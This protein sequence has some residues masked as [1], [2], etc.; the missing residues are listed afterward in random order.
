MRTR[1]TRIGALAALLVVCG[2]LSFSATSTAT[3]EI[4]KQAKA[5]GVDAKNCQTCHTVAM[6]KKGEGASELNDCGKWL[7]SQKEAKK[8]KEVDGAWAKDCPKK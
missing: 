6:P 2:W 8:A 3:M 5:A 4:Q 1:V 7:M